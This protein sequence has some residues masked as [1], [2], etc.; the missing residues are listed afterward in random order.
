MVCIHAFNFTVSHIR[1]DIRCR[2]GD[3]YYSLILISI[4]AWM[5][6]VFCNVRLYMGAFERYRM[7]GLC[8]AGLHCQVRKKDK[9]EF[10]GG[11]STLQIECERETL[12]WQYTA[13]RQSVARRFESQGLNAFIGNHTRGSIP[14]ITRVK[15]FQHPFKSHN[16]DAF[17]VVFSFN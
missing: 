9:C 14:K 16:S 13:S 12:S 8:D 11:C 15:R 17:L 6:C 3:W 7:S 4:S 1:L 2:L 5:Y 10:F